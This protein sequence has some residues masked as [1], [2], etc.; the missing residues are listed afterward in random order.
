MSLINVNA[1][2]VT[3]AEK[4]SAAAVEIKGVCSQMLNLNTNSFTRIFN[5]VWN[6][7]NGLTPQQVCDALATDAGSLFALAGGLQAVINTAQAGSLTLTPPKAVTVNS[8]GTVT[9]G[10]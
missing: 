10:A 3:T 4:Q 2:A 7:R 5:I 1:P 9:I 8:D 6:N